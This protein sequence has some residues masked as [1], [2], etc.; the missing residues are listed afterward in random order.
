MSTAILHT[1]HA[2]LTIVLALNQWL[3]TSSA[4]EDAMFIATVRAKGKTPEFI[5]APH[6]T[7]EAAVLEALAARPTAKT[8]STCNAFQVD[9][10]WFRNW[11]N[12]YFHDRN[13][14]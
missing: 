5:S 11:T 1:S 12:I 14:M 13:R 3:C 10:T 6:D 4:T 7:R 9:G 8:A 2:H